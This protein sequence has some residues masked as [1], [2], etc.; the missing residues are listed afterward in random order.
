MSQTWSLRTQIVVLAGV[1]ALG[2]AGW[3]WRD[4]I[5]SAFANLA[6]TA[7]PSAG[8]RSNTPKGRKNGGRA[9]PVIVS[10]I[11]SRRNDQSVS[12]IGSARAFRSVTL[13]SETDGEVMQ[14]TVSAGDRVTKGDLIVQLD[15]YQATTSLRLAE[16]TLQDVERK[17][18]RV[19]YLKKR[20][21]NSGASVEDAQIAVDRAE[22]EVRRAKSILRDT[23]LSA[24]FDGIVGIPKIE[25]GDRVTTT[26]EIVTL[27][28]RSTL[29]VEFEVPEDFISRIAPGDRV[30]AKTPGFGDRIFEGHLKAIDSRIDPTSRTVTVRAAFPNERDILRPGMSFAI[31]LELPGK[32]YPAAPELALQWRQGES[33]VWV[34]ENGKAKRIKVD[35]VRRLNGIVLLKGSL[36]AGDL[37]VV[38]GVQRLRPGRAVKMREPQAGPALP[39]EDTEKSAKHRA[40]DRAAR[41]K[42]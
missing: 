21:I 33:F 11:E 30:T 23:R 41:Q 16:K 9:V 24:P 4:T 20:N 31:D 29:L 10:R 14:L 5:Q 22:L 6:P 40:P 1:T 2:A 36:N 17:L 35:L 3:M 19:E 42:G 18:T 27:D 7:S 38:E 37:I 32:P 39:T 25:V 34:I 15:D 12:A 26:T 8:D 13:F 28:D